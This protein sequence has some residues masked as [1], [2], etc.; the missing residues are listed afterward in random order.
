M[1][2]KSFHVSKSSGGSATSLSNP[3]HCN[4]KFIE[5]LCQSHMRGARSCT[6][7][8]RYRTRHSWAVLALHWTCLR[9]VCALN[10]NL[11]ALSF[12]FFR[13]SPLNMSR[14]RCR[15][16]KMNCKRVESWAIDRFIAK[17]REQTQK[18]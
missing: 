17:G 3:E 12:F 16:I 2:C 15:Y 10:T 11:V 8:E 9:E 1:W 7:E 5:C 6:A 13:D 18:I 14:V 4:P